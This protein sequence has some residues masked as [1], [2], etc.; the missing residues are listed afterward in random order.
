MKIRNLTQNTLIASQANIAATPLSRIIGLLNRSSLN[1]EE[2]LIIQ[3]CQSIH[4]FFMKFSIDV[5]FVD[6]AD[7]VVGLVQGIKPYQ[8][9]PIFF[10]ASYAIEVQE[11]VIRESKTQLGD[12]LQ[13]VG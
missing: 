10:K 1:P 5:I 3:R 2:A 4:M 9:S 13:L 6:R 12:Q 8:L 7:C 11:G